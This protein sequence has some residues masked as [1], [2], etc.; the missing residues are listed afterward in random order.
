[1]PTLV[2]EYHDQEELPYSCGLVVVWWGCMLGC[3]AAHHTIYINN[4]FDRWC[5]GWLSSSMCSTLYSVYKV[6]Q[7]LDSNQRLD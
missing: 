3:G 5:D 4:T 2:Q 7:T 1:M 6:I